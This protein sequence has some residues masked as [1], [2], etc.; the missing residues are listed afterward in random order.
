[1]TKKGLYIIEFDNGIKF[2]ITSNIDRRKIAY[3]SP[4]D[5]EIKQSKFFSCDKP[6]EIESELKRHFKNKTKKGST[7]FVY[8]VS[9]EDIVSVVI[10]GI[11]L[12]E[13][14]AVKWEKPKTKN[15]KFIP[16]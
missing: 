9:F 15:T 12:L 7:E 16:W 10:A 8:G 4:W 13:E 1:M 2:G 14:K 11:F 5:R 3:L 6:E